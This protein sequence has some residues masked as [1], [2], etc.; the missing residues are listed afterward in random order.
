MGVKIEPHTLPCLPEKVVQAGVGSA[1]V[2][3]ANVCSQLEPTCGS[4]WSLLLASNLPDGQASSGTGVFLWP[5]CLHLLWRLHRM[6]K[7]LAR[8]LVLNQW[9]ESP[10]A[11]LR[12]R[13]YLHYDLQQ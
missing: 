7:V 10:L 13:K 4:P 11:N 3:A 1:A 9:V 8:A 5:G 12:L 6:L 2:S